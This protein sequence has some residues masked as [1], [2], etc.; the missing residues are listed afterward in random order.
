MTSVALGGDDSKVV[1]ADPSCACFDG[2]LEIGA[3]V[4]GILPEEDCHLDDAI[5]GGLILGYYFTPNIGVEYTGAFYGTQ[6][7]THNSTLDLVYRFVNRDKCFAPYILGGGGVHANSENVNVW[8]LGAGVD[9]RFDALGCVG[10]FGDG[11]YTWA[12]GDV[13]DYTL[14]RLGVKIPF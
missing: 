5:G 3:F 2:K 7:E 1:I 8:R 14:V 4:G 10:L 13:A 12:G 6:S 9:L 11:V